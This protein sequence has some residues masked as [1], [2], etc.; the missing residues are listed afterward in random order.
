MAWQGGVGPQDEVKDTAAR[1]VRRGP[2]AAVVSVDDR[3]RVREPHPIPWCLVVKSGMKMVFPTYSSP[4]LQGVE[5]TA[6]DSFHFVRLAHI[7]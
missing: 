1:G 3:A 4:F 7:A 5:K 6:F 2:E